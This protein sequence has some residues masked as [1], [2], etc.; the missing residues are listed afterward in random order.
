M[1]SCP[2]SPPGNDGLDLFDAV[3]GDESL[4]HVAPFPQAY[5]DNGVDIGM[6]V[7]TLYRVDDYRLAVQFQELFWT[8]SRIHPLS[9]SSRKDY[10]NVHLSLSFWLHA[11]KQ[12][13]KFYG[14]V[15]TRGLPPWWYII[16]GILRE[17]LVAA[18]QG[19]KIDG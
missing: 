17:M 4:E 7:E 5:D 12:F 10:G 3:V 19:E 13:F 1:D 18:G 8:G 14:H 15:E 9:G 11:I 6:L 2:V 16:D